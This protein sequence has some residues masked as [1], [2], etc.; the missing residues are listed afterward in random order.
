MCTKITWNDFCKGTV[1]YLFF[2]PGNNK[3]C[4]YL[5]WKPDK[6]RSYVIVG[7]NLE[8]YLN[9]RC[10]HNSVKF[11]ISIDLLINQEKFI[12]PPAKSM[13]WL[14]LLWDSKNWILIQSSVHIT[15]K[16]KKHIITKIKS[17]GGRGAHSCDKMSFPIE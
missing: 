16:Q 10:W 13:E 3:R 14:G 12:F 7:V 6:R 17:R 1:F 9:D 5:G 4:G 15:F 11:C 8:S 2:K